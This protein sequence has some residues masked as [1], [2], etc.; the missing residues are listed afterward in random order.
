ML[1]AL[2]L[3]S[4]IRGAGIRWGRW[5]IRHSSCCEPRASPVAAGGYQRAVQS[6]IY[7]GQRAAR[8]MHFS[9][10]TTPRGAIKIALQISASIQSLDSAQGAVLHCPATMLGA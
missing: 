7:S 3:L 5:E 2:T 10:F 8:V 4:W 9:L 1:L 6:T